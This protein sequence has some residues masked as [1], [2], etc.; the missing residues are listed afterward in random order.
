MQQKLDKEQVRKLAKRYTLS[1][2]YYKRIDL[3][4]IMIIYPENYLEF[5]E[6]IGKNEYEKAVGLA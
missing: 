3:I 2:P 4:S 5:V 1:T 6:L